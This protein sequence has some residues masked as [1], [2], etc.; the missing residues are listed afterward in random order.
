MA[1][2]CFLHGDRKHSVTAQKNLGHPY[3]L[4]L[5]DSVA[6]WVKKNTLCRKFYFDTAYLGGASEMPYESAW[7]TAS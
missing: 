4:H 1:T 3:P 5:F 7:M 6:L 2:E